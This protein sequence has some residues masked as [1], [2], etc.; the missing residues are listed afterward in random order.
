[1]LNLITFNR[2][3]DTGR[4][5]N[6]YL[7]PYKRR[8]FYRLTRYLNVRQILV[9]YGL[10]RTGKTTLMYQLIDF[11]LKEGVPRKQI[12]YFSFDEKVSRLEELLKTYSDLIISKDLARLKKIYIFLDETQKLEDWENQL[13]IFYD[14]YPNIKFIVSGSASI[15]IQK[16]ASESLAGRIYEFILPLL[17]FREF[18]E[19]KGESVGIDIDKSWNYKNLREVYLSKERISPYLLEYTKKG[20]FIELTN[21][22]DEEKVRNYAQS[23][24]EKVTFIDLPCSFNL[25]YPQLLRVIVDLIAS[26]PGFLLDYVSLSQTLGR[27]KRV[28]A[29]YFFYLKYSLLVKS[30]YNFSKSRF[31]S[32]KKLKRAYLGSTNFIYGIYPERFFEPRFLGKIM[33]NLVVI[34]TDTQFF[35][36]LRNYEVDVVTGSNLPIEVKYKD[37]ITDKET[38]SII[39]FCKNFD[40]GKGIVVT[41]DF[42]D[43]RVKEEIKLLYIPLWVFLLKD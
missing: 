12:L 14:L 25:K 13:K 28:I 40:M 11:L 21:E 17:P 5:D 36:R 15:T 20:G 10:R 8:L 4:V 33:E 42:L 9:I 43:C 27:D 32:E 38:G 3:W 30:L 18:L 37:K 41:R 24:V 35:W 1:M 29:D 6:I 7:M 19:L 31:T 34:N 16:K 2:W 39:K 22:S 23:I 26:N